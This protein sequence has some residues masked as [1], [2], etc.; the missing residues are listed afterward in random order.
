MGGRLR[1]P[2]W[3]RTTS[4]PERDAP[5]R[6]RD[7]LDQALSLADDAARRTAVDGVVQGIAEGRYGPGFQRRAEGTPARARQAGAG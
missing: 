1:R 5:R 6:L 2:T 7:D 3:R 4:G